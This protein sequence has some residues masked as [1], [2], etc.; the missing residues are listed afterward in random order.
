MMQP[1]RANKEIFVITGLVTGLA[2]IVFAITVSG[3]SWPPPPVPYDRVKY[4]DEVQ[5]FFEY[6]PDAEVA[7]S[8]SRCYEESCPPYDEIELKYWSPD[9]VGTAWLA[10]RIPHSGYEP[11][12]FT[13]WCNRGD[14][15]RSPT[16]VS[17]ERLDMSSFLTDTNCPPYAPK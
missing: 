2:S 8:P 3:F 10:A 14:D 13:A 12:T 5:A 15:T 9:A 1:C 4:V 17:G 7:S 6:Y 16:I 11:P